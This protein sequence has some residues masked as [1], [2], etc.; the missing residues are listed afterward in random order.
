MADARAAAVNAHSEQRQTD[1][2]NRTS[3]IFIHALSQDMEGSFVRDED[4]SAKP[5][6]FVLKIAIMISTTRVV[7]RVCKRVTKQ[8]MRDFV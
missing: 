7:D 8:D 6:R 4:C 1:S 3:S 2:I 5:A